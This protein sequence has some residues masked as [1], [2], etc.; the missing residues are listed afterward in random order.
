MVVTD[1]M[2]LIDVTDWR[3]LIGGYRRQTA[4]TAKSWKLPRIKRA[5]LFVFSPSSTSA[6]RKRRGEAMHHSSLRFMLPLSRHLI[7]KK[8]NPFM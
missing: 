8:R 5:P 3:L 2:L 1:W 7:Q 4:P 6:A